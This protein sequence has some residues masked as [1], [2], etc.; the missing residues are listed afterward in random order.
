ML[1][2]FYDKSIWKTLLVDCPGADYLRSRNQ[3][4]FFVSLFD[5]PPATGVCVHPFFWFDRLVKC[6][7]RVTFCRRQVSAPF[8]WVRLQSPIPNGPL[9][10]SF[11]L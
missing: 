6:I 11:A 1:S 3:N 4:V 2:L 9:H 10:A 8:V 7:P 5:I